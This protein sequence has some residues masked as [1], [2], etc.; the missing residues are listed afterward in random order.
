MTESIQSLGLIA[1]NRSLPLVL[2]KQARTL[3]VK[4]LVAVAFE[5]ET[6]PVLAS[7]VDEIVWLKVGQLS[8]LISAFT[9]RKIKHCVMAGQIAPKNLYDL[10]PDLRAMA[11]LFRLK[12]KNA[13][14]V[15]GAIAEELKKDGVDLIEATPWLKPVMPG[16]GFR[17]G[18]KLSEG[19]QADLAFGYRIAKEVSR[20][21]IG[22]TVVVKNGTVLAVEGFEG[23]DKCLARGGELAGREGGA[24]A[25][26]VA[27]EKH[28]LRFDLPCLGPT[29]LETCAAARISVLGF[30][31]GKSLLLEQETCEHLANK[32]KISVTTIG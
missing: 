11:L 25:V 26:K 7:L 17:L 23:T 24:V 14:T 31:A 9:D 12:E 27:K 10:R 2:A 29:T 20:L 13:H 3:G 8:K 5:G 1:G 19:Q 6:D 22:Q 21:E 28:D 16:S 30:E 32:N 18:P 15:F 4:R